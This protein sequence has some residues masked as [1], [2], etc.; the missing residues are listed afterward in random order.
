VAAADPSVRFNCSSPGRIGC[1]VGECLSLG[2]SHGQDHL[3]R[4]LELAAL[5]YI[6]RIEESFF[7]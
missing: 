7:E 2:D 1:G 4:L 6:R 3:Q 5:P